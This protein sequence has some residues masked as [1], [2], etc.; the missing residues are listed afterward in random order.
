MVPALVCIVVS[1]YT[2]LCTDMLETDLEAFAILVY[3]K[4]L[5]T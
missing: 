4:T 5:A 2:C 1:I 3:M